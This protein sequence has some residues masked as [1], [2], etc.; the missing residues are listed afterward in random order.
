MKS[1][2]KMSYLDFKGHLGPFQLEEFLSLNA[3]YPFLTLTFYCLLAKYAYQTQDL[4]QWVIGNAYLLCTNICIFSLGI[5]F[6][7]ERSN[8][9]I[10]SIICAPFS[11]LRFMI[12]KSLFPCMVCVV[13][14]MIGFLAGGVLFQIP[15]ENIHWGIFVIILITAM[16]GACA[17]GLFIGTFGLLTDQMHLVL[18]T[19]S[20][21]LLIF[22]GS[23]FPVSQLP[24]W[25]KIISQLLP[26]SR[27]IE[28]VKL[29]L[30]NDVNHKLFEYL[31]G[32]FFV[33]ICYFILAAA[34]VYFSERMAMK[35]G[36]IELF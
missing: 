13:T 35:R 17:L 30:S 18:N 26:L 12:Q 5:S 24:F 11:K 3:L 8:G 15:F 23:N 4:T 34:M 20:F 31:I 32:E 33:C 6:Y 7:G 1:F 19:M 9:R 2:F 36:T 14:T 28:A 25:G 22:T 16:M 21:V 29:L 10:R 27:S